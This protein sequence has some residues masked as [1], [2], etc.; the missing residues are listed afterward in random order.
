MR[1]VRAR[2][3]PTPSGLGAQIAHGGVRG[4]VAGGHPA[5]EAIPVAADEAITREVNGLVGIGIRGQHL[6]CFRSSRRRRLRCSGQQRWRPRSALLWA[7][8][9]ARA[10]A[11]G[12]GGGSVTSMSIC[13]CR[14]SRICACTSTANACTPP[15]V[16]AAFTPTA[17]CT[18]SAPDDAQNDADLHLALARA[19]ESDRADRSR[20]ADRKHGA[21]RG[22]W[23][24]RSSSTFGQ[25]YLEGWVSTGSLPLSDG[26]YGERDL[27]DARTFQQIEHVDD[28]AVLDF[29]VGADH[30][31]QIG[32]LGLGGTRQ[33]RDRLVARRRPRNRRASCRRTRARPKT[34]AARP[35]RWRPSVDPWACPARR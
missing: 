17:P 5:R 27:R 4:A 14:R 9:G 22:R 19:R 8:A 21:V 2:A 34:P 30:G 7:P 35:R 29:F 32:S 28:A 13:E 25:L 20:A 10:R 26:R 23:A 3:L 33:R 1:R 12:G 31:A 6:A 16:L 15:S 18:K 24:R 11:A